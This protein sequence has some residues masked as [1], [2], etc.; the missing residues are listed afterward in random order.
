MVACTHVMI[1][2]DV[3]NSFLLFQKGLEMVSLMH[4]PAFC[5][6]YSRIMIIHMPSFLKCVF[7]LRLNFVCHLSCY[8]NLFPHLLSEFQLVLE[9]QAAEIAFRFSSLQSLNP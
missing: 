5:L 3:Q 1:K 4:D 7:W 8:T 6:Y 9:S 2:L